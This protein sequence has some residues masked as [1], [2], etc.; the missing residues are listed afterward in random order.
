MAASTMTQWLSFSVNTWPTIVPALFRA[1][2]EL[3]KPSV[4]VWPLSTFAVFNVSA[5]VGTGA[6][7]SNSRLRDDVDEPPAVK[8]T[9]AP[10]ATRLSGCPVTVL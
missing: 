7:K 10:A 5:F 4:P 6:R 3:L 8:L 2:Q 9:L 1:S